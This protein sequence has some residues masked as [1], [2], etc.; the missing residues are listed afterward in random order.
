M[1]SLQSSGVEGAK[2]DAP[3]PDGLIADSDASLGEEVFNISVTEIESIVEPNCVADDV[4]RESMTLVYIH[5]PI[6][7]ILAI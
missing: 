7:S 1:L 6:L 3:Q 5:P 4:R 2:F